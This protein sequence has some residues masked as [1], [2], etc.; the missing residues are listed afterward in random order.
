MRKSAICICKNK[1]ADQ[2]HSYCAADQHLFFS[3]IDFGASHYDINTV[4]MGFNHF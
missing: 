2:L 3:Y 1:G 4:E